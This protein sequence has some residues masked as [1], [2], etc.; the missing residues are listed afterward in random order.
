MR[1]RL[2]NNCSYDN[3]FCMTGS[4]S[5]M[6]DRGRW[7]VQW[8]CPLT[9]KYLKITRYTPTWDFLISEQLA[10]KQLAIVQRDWEMHLQ[11]LSHFRPEKYTKRGST[12]V[13]TYFEEWMA[14][15][16]EPKRAPA[17]IKG[18]RS[19]F[20]NWI[21][22]FFKANP[23]SLH[24]I[25]LD[26][27]FKFMNSIKRSPKMKL[28]VIMCVHEMLDYAY[29]SNR[30]PTM[31]PFPKKEEYGI[32]D[33]TIEWIPF[34]QQESIIAAIPD[35]HRPIFQWLMLHFRREGEAF[36]LHKTDYDVI[37]NAFIIR[38]SVSAR[39]VIQQ[40][41][42]KKVHVIPCA[43]EFTETAKKLINQNLD[44][45]YLF[46]N[47]RARKDG[48][49]YTHESANIIWKDACKKVGIDIPLYH[50]VKHSSCT[51]FIEQGGTV[52]ELQIMTDHARRESVLKYADISVRRKREM[53]RKRTHLQNT[54]KPPLTI[55]K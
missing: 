13:V 54:H 16:I 24:E 46:V 2:N 48:R 34:E 10:R 49:R 19:Y 25:Q 1:T 30:I 14:E 29:R 9:K 12:D 8:Y 32:V 11:G 45:P 15:I 44:S 23:V 55:I 50:G 7:L 35:E 43:D 33:S 40:T 39:T 52:D 38:R 31:P 6:K 41:K 42:T 3:K 36:A 28:N 17:T 4:I 53:M 26:T 51:N 27:I 22:P 5:F 21:E 37:N 47:C 20:R 18:Y